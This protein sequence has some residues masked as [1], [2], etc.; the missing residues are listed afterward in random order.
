MSLL[1][2]CGSGSGTIGKT[3][4][5]SNGGGITV[6][7]GNEGQDQT[8]GFLL[9][10]VVGPPRPAVRLGDDTTNVTAIAGAT[11]TSLIQDRTPIFYSD[12]DVNGYQQIFSVP[13]CGGT[14]TQIT[15]DSNNHTSPAVSPDGTKIAYEFEIGEIH[16]VPIS[17]NGNPI[18]ISLGTSGGYAGH[19]A[20]SPDGTRI[21]FLG[22]EP[23]D[24]HHIFTASALDGTGIQVLNPKQECDFSCGPSWSSDGTRIAYSA[25]DNRSRSQIFTISA[26]GGQYIPLTVNGGSEPAWSPDGTRIAFSDGQI[27]TLPARGGT[28]TPINTG[29]PHSGIAPAW[30]PDSTRIAFS[31]ERNIFT[32][33]ASGGQGSPIGR[34]SPLSTLSWSPIVS[35][36][37]LLGSNGLI[38]TAAAGLLLGE[39]GNTITALAFDTAGAPASRAAALV[40]PYS[41]E[42]LIFQVKADDSFTQNLSPQINYVS[43]NRLDGTILSR[44]TVD[45]PNG[46]KGAV[47]SFDGTTGQVATISPYGIGAS[48]VG[49][50]PTVVQQGSQSV[51]Q[52]HFLAVFDA[53]G[54]NLAPHGASQ[55]HLDSKTGEL[56]SVQ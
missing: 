32:V 46:T 45:L 35:R 15:R 24:I 8:F 33:S 29:P 44:E 25:F 36:T 4:S 42:R 26:S 12:S 39:S 27:Y 1:T 17:G 28:P 16:I 38:G 56:L 2:G 55:I 31:H 48:S 22:H 53:A 50:A 11:F 40:V 23:G 30:S 49:S 14:P 51:F 37:Q 3:L 43:I 54:K 47:V 9:G 18:K 7:A 13:A 21:A 10:R 19:P 5:G 34:L 6:G 41:T 20:W 52:G